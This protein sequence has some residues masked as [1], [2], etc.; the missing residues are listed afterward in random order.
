M[1]RAQFIT[2]S[3]AHVKWGLNIDFHFARIVCLLL[4]FTKFRNLEKS[5]FKSEG[6]IS[7]MR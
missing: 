4:H 3:G 6:N 1:V 7:V 2:E 5:W